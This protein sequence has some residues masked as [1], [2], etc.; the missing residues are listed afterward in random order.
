MFGILT[1]S[2]ANE[3]I[4]FEGW[5]IH[6]CTIL[7][8][9]MCKIYFLVYSGINAQSN[10]CILVACATSEKTKRYLCP[11]PRAPKAAIRLPQLPLFQVA[12]AG[13]PRSFFVKICLRQFPAA[14]SFESLQVSSCALLGLRSFVGQAFVLKS[15]SSIKR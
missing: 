13:P 1:Y 6:L 2:S 14:R 4:F 8:R 15:L 11:V 3:T 7:R 10:L 9:G 12:D 5:G